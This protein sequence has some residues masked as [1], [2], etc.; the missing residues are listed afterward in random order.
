MSNH[1]IH[2]L[3]VDDDDVDV[4]VVKRAFQRQKINNPMTVAR[5]GVEAL[6]MLR[7]ENGHTAVPQPLLILL[8][9][10]MPRMGGL[11]FLEHLREDPAFHRTVVF[12]LTTSADDSDR[13]AAYD[14]NI[15]GYLVKSDAGRDLVNHMPLLE[16]FLLCVQFPDHA[17]NGR[18]TATASTNA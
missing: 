12:V 15:A 11:Q 18:T 9:L 5:D 7:G 2:I 8:D 1:P 6:E 17:L 13:Q 4:R 14:Q 10:K 3:L 16:N